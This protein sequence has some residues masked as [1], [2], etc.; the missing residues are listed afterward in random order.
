VTTRA[1]PACGKPVDTLRAG[2]VAILDGE[3]RYFCDEACKRSH[4]VAPDRPAPS[5]V[6]TAEPP[7]VA[8][9]PPPPVVAPTP[10]A[11]TAPPAPTVEE[12]DA[13]DVPVVEPAPLVEEPVREPSVGHHPPARPARPARPRSVR[14]AAAAWTLRAERLRALLAPSAAALGVFVGLLVPSL[15]LLGPGAQAARLPLATAAMLACVG[16]AL[17]VPR[18]PSDVH[19]LASALS[20]AAVWG[21]AAYA[22]SAGD[23]RALALASVAGLAAAVHLIGALLVD[24]AREGVRSARTWIR[25]RLDVPARVLRGDEAVLVPAADVKPGEEIVASAGDTLG[26]DVRVTAGL[27]LVTPWID[28][29]IEVTKKE[30]DPVVAGAR[31]VSG[32]LR[33]V[34]TWSGSDRAWLRLVDSPDL[35]PDVV[36][37]LPR[38][39]RLTLERGVL[40]AVAL[41]AILARLNGATGLDILAMGAVAA[42]SMI[43]TWACAIV[44][45]H[46]ARGP[47]S[48]LAHGVVY[49]DAA[50]FDRAGQT[51]IA[52]LC[53]RT[54]L[55]LGSPEIVALEALTALDVGRV[56]VLAAGASTASPHAGSA[57]IIAA[58]RVRGEIPE[59][60]RHAS[61][62][63]GLGVTA[64]SSTGEHLVVGSRAL[65]LREKVSIAAADAR[66][67]RLEGEGRSVTLVAI[68][69]RLVGLIALQDGLRPGAR[70]A[71]QRLLDAHIE[72]V[73]LSGE[74]RETCETLGRALD[75]DHLRPE[76]LP[77]DRANEVR[78]VADGGHVV[79]VLGHPVDDAAALGAADVSV[80]LGAAGATTGDWGISLASEDVRDAARALTIAAESRA[81]TRI[82]IALALAPG[83]IAAVGIA[84][85][86]LPLALGPLLSLAGLAA[87]VVHARR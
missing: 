9:A 22:R 45:L 24:R 7:R 33:G 34:T 2:H 69:G 40:V 43:G 15:G 83:G 73:L 21:T 32:S 42:F 86:L 78:R 82:A 81:R 41:V 70:A 80:V 79:A 47:I 65:L 60:I 48:A 49:R 12:E 44:G 55:L 87:A 17:V 75:I 19:P 31:V 77:P 28:S 56:L 57:A 29:T 1:C 27:A 14:S 51:D 84:L 4:L 3:F 66:V 35:R 37:P 50:A 68:G 59:S 67:T 16:R 30:G 25:R 6:E 26:V 11:A 71:V 53:S 23:A 54:T 13:D 8:P 74:A 58:A 72:P 38:A 62:H 18:D 10:A 36:G 63:P 20:V 76:V 85:G 39:V 52:I 61:Y 5:H 46:Q 64:L